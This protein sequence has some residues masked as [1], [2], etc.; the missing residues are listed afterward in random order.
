MQISMIIAYSIKI[1]EQNIESQEG[2]L[3]QAENLFAPALNFSLN[4][5]VDDLP[6][7]KSTREGLFDD[8]ILS[9]QNY[10]LTYRLSASKVF[11]S[12]LTLSPE[13]RLN[14][15]G[16]DATYDLY[17]ALGMGEFVTNTGSLFLYASQPLLNG[18]GSA[19]AAAS[20]N[21]QKLQLS[22]AQLEYQ[23]DVSR[24]AFIV[25][26]NYLSYLGSRYSFSINSQVLEGLIT[27]RDQLTEL[28]DKDVIPKADLLYVRANYSQQSAFV[29]QSKNNVIRSRN[30]LSE[31][32]GLGGERY[33]ELETSQEE[34]FVES[35]EIPD[36]S[37]Y[38][39]YWMKK[40]LENRGDYQGL[41]KRV[42][43]GDV[44]IQ[45][46]ERNNAPRLDLNLGV[47]YNGIYES[48]SAEQYVAPFYSNIPGMSYTAGV[49]F[50]MPF[51]LKNTKGALR[52]AVAN[53]ESLAQSL[54][55]LELNI[56]QSVASSYSEV[57]MYAEAVSQFKQAV[58]TNA[59]ALDNE[60][61]KL[62]LGTTTV[63]NLIQVQQN[64]ANSRSN[65]NS[66][67]GILNA[68][69]IKFRYQTGTLVNGEGQSWSI[70]PTEIFS[71]PAIGK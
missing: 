32:M 41:K 46:A 26:Q 37:K 47:G 33:P 54:R 23:N 10:L 61:I 21:I 9:Y 43:S 20:L 51:G 34:F 19:S 64:A 58:A 14:N 68:A 17:Q 52:S 4:N 28:A 13:F 71:L 65:L 6:Y 31:S 27:Y 11:K 49:S 2:F 12:G 29:S 55:S 59:E 1:S 7:T 5:S 24:Q 69:I 38:V 15:F 53:R 66:Y 18:R 39:T 45:F 57:A 16:K 44:N 50:S 70:N 42:E 3:L 8:P 62:K 60:Y 56:Q 48:N 63:V 67:L 36:S 22:A 30:S 35:I 40:A 25:V